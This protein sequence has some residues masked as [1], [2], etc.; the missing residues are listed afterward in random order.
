[1][2]M[3]SPAPPP[4]RVPPL[5]PAGVAGRPKAEPRKGQGAEGAPKTAQ[6][7]TE[8]DVLP[9]LR[10]VKI[11][12]PSSLGPSP[13]LLPSRPRPQAPFPGGPRVSQ[14]PSPTT[15]TGRAPSQAPTAGPAPSRSLRS[16]GAPPALPQS[17]PPGRAADWKRKHQPAQGCGESLPAPPRPGPARPSAVSLLG[18]QT[19]RWVDL[20]SHRT[21]EAGWT[22]AWARGW[23]A[24]RPGCQ[25]GT[26]RHSLRGIFR[27]GPRMA[28]SGGAAPHGPSGSAETHPPSLFHCQG[29]K[30]QS[31]A[32]RSLSM[33]WASGLGEGRLGHCPRPKPLDGS[34]TLATL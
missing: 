10:E 34:L 11:Q 3:P 17:A 27:D 24:G 31:R 12:T 26:W 8:A 29:H 28:P 16:R 15:G 25:G 14:D 13:R 7:L 4:P 30:G 20:L 6:L 18:G 2:E 19:G 22:P 1:M 33:A 23:G 21:I 9:T 32:R 5:H